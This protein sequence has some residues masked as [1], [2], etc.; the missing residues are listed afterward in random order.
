MQSDLTAHFTA[1]FAPS[2]DVT[3]RFALYYADTGHLILGRDRLVLDI[4]ARAC[5]R[6]D[7]EPVGH[8][9]SPL[10]TIRALSCS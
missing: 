8:R 9:L 1:R 10:G 3:T 5:S 7:H 4:A 2:M 6:R